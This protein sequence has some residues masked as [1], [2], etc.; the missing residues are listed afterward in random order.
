MAH[1]ITASS[2]SVVV[3]TILF[4][5]SFHSAI[6]GPAAYGVCQAGCSAVVVACYAAAGAVFGTVTAGIGTPHAIVACNTAYGTCQS[7]CWTALFSPTP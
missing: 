6:A 7:A 2:P 1:K 4:L 5:I 3:I